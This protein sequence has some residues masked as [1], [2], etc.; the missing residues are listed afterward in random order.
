MISTPV[1]DFSE[2]FVLPMIAID[3]WIFNNAI[4]PLTSSGQSP[5][6]ATI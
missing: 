2:C 1:G 3:E 6:F 5:D 4:F